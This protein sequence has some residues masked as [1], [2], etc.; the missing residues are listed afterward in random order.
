MI[1]IYEDLLDPELLDALGSYV[2]TAPWK[3]GWMSRQGTGFPHWNFEI[4]HAG[5]KNLLSIEN[6]IPINLVP[7]WQVIKSFNPA[8]YPIRCYA[9]SHTFGVEGYP[10]TDSTRDNETTYIVY[11]NPE[12]KRNWGGETAFYEGEDIIK[13][14][15]P[16]FGRVVEFSSNIWHCARS[17]SRI[18]PAQRFTLMIKV[19]NPFEDK[20]LMKIDDFLKKVG[21]YHKKHKHGTLAEH[22]IRVY[23]LLVV[24]GFPEYVCLAGAIHSIYG[25]D[26]YPNACCFEKD[27]PIVR[28]VFGDPAE[29]LAWIF[30]HLKNRT[31]EILKTYPDQLW[32]LEAA[33]LADQGVLKKYPKLKEFWNKYE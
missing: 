31:Q 3:Y 29:E 21:A 32:I 19:R 28:G 9:N 8:A 11:L 27:R 16:K 4:V 12:W 20:T 25:T 6:K 23:E 7:Y 17:V 5:G 14:V 22:L 1:N 15:M 30:G 26:S 10:H 33:N 2:K 24:K 13:S 18:C